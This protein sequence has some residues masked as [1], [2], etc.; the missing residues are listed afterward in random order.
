MLIN[1][2]RNIFVTTQKR[3]AINRP[4]TY[5]KLVT[6]GSGQD[7]LYDLQMKRKAHWTVFPVRP[8]GFFYYCELTGKWLQ[9]ELWHKSYF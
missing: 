8:E 6:K 4:A 9:S 3:V 5:F 7:F 2:S 1:C